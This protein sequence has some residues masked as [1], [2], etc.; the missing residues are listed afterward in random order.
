[1]K[2]FKAFVIVLLAMAA[3]LTMITVFVPEVD[4]HAEVMIEKPVIS[5]YAG[6]LN[7][8]TMTEWVN[9]LDSIEREDGFLAMPGSKFRLHYKGRET[10]TVQTLE[11]LEIV[12]LRSIKFKLYDE[13][14]EMTI[15]MDFESVDGGTKVESYL[16][17]KGKGYMS[18]AFL[19]LLRSVILEEGRENL[20]AFKQLQEK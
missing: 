14:L 15:T 5:V 4:G 19:P 9:G 2:F 18:R 8:G 12:P 20:A 10:H 3:I 17:M 7:T 1:M 11:V 16:Q 13:M 6:M